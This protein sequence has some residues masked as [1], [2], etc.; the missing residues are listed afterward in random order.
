MKYRIKIAVMLN[1]MKT[2][3]AIL[4]RTTNL[5]IISLIWLFMNTNSFISSISQ[6]SELFL[7][8]SLMN[9]G[10][11]LFISSKIFINVN[12][13]KINRNLLKIIEN[14]HQK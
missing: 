9:R 3:M 1:T 11:N 10:F 13:N 5:N 4:V 6:T 12:N 8:Q 14:C 7:M 2:P